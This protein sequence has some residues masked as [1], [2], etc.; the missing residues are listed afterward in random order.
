MM[1][2][3]D[4]SIRP[5][6]G[7][8]AGTGKDRSQVIIIGAGGVGRTTVLAN[9]AIMEMKERGVDVVFVDDVRTPHVDNPMLLD[10]S[11]V[12]NGKR[13]VEREKK[14][15]RYPRFGTPMARLLVE[16]AI[17]HIEQSRAVGRPVQCDIIK[18]FG[19]IQQKKS[20]LT[21]SQRQWV[22]YQF[23]KLYEE[24]KEWK[25]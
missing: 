24:I 14:E 20:N 11:F 4:D 22:V 5:H 16:A 7:F 2:E 3:L 15:R 13:Y 12:V 23:N 18:E 9:R 25:P 8:D 21:A 19:L 6:I 10:D 17:N 1:E